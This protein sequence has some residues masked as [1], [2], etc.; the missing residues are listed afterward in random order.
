MK[1]RKPNLKERITGSAY[2]LKRLL[3]CFM[4]G[5][6]FLFAKWMLLEIL[7]GNFEIVEDE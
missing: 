5:Q 3:E 2:W 7:K 4:K 6:D 1:T